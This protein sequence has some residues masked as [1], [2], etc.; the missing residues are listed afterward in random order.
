MRL[1]FYSAM[2]LNRSHNEGCVFVFNRMRACTLI[3]LSHTKQ[4][5][6]GNVKQISGKSNCVPI[7]RKK[8]L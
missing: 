3:S 7:R 4:D 2:S 8:F 5:E 6:A 1:I